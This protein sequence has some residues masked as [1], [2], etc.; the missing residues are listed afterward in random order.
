MELNELRIQLDQIDREMVSLFERRM[1]VC[2]DVARWKAENGRPILDAS[3]EKEKLQSVAQQ[4]P[5]DLQEYGMSL[6]SLMME[7]SR[8]SQTRLLG[9]EKDLTHAIQSAIDHTTP[10]FPPSAMVA[11]QGVEG[12]YSQ[13]AAEKLFRHPHVM[14]FSNFEAVFAAIEK[15][16]CRYG[17]IPLENSTAGSVNM[18]YDLMM[19]HNFR[20]VRSVRLK[21]DHNLLAKS[22]VKLED[23]REV[24]SHEQAIN[25]CSAFL[26][27]HPEIRVVRCANTAEA[28]RMVSQSDRRDI[29]ALSSRACA[30]LYGLQ[31]LAPSC[32]NQGNNYTRFICIS[33]ELEIYPGA[34][35]TS[36]MVVLPH[37]PGSLYKLLSRFYALGI[38]LNKLESRPLPDRDFEFMFY[39]DLDTSVYSP[40]FLQLMG[41]LDTVC[42]SFTY[43]GSYSEVI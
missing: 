37:R 14:Y 29:A 27:A 4:L 40:Q 24:Y 10:L 18:V 30:E 5:E 6:Y 39:F 33:R 19:R 43:L 25:Q 13:Q 9:H 12:A 3:R 26:Q 31:N 38:N 22:G 35:R 11:C 1:R 21:V 36:L 8:S 15:G 23:I 41:E 34:D 42:E 2:E 20:I 16:L 32:Q 28:A 7:L 17:V